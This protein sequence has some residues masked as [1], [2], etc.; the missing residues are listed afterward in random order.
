MAGRV[1][2]A[3][4]GELGDTLS[5]NPSFSLFTKRYSRYTN[6]A[7]ENYKISFP[8]GVFT[9]DFLDVPIPQK[10]GDILQEV[11]L[12]FSV[13][14]NEVDNFY[15]IDVFGISA[16]EY[17]ELYVGDEKI[18]TITAD[19][20]FIDRELNV[21]ESYRSS[22]DV[23]HGKHFQ[24][25]SEREFL[26]EFYD[27]QYNTQ[28][29][30]PFSTNEYRIQIPFYFHRRPGNG[31]PLCAIQDQELSL[32]IK[33]RPA[34]DV[35]FATQT[36]GEG[37]TLWDPAANN[38][39]TQQFELKDFKVN[40]DLVHLNT[41]E[42]CMIRSKPIDILFEQRQR[43]TFLIDPQSKSG[44]FKLDLKN[45]VKELFFI[46]KKTGQWSEEQVSLM[47]R[48]YELDNYTTAQ[49]ELL[50]ILKLIPV[51]GGVVSTTLD[52][53]THEDEQSVR[54][55]AI[56]VIRNNII[57]GDTQIGV[58]N[59][60]R[61]DENTDVSSL[62]TYITNIPGTI[63]DNQINATSNL[64]SLVGVTDGPTRADI[65]DS[66]LVS[67]ENFWGPEQI[68][69]LQALKNPLL[70]GT[71]DEEL[72][73]LGLRVY[74]T[75]VSYYLGG[76]SGLKPGTTDQL[77]TIAKLT[78]FLDSTKFTYDILKTGLKE[79]LNQIPGKTEYFRNIIVDAILI[80]GTSL[81]GADQRT[82]LES[83]RTVPVVSGDITTQ[84]QTIDELIAYLN[85]KVDIKGTTNASLEELRGETSSLAR[86]RIVNGLLAI[87]DFWGPTEEGNLR[88]LKESGLV[89]EDTLIDNLRNYV[90]A[91]TVN[92][93]A[94]LKST[95]DTIL[96]NLPYIP[97]GESRDTT[98]DGLDIADFWGTTEEG[99]LTTLK[100]TTPG[101]QEETELI[102][103]L[104]VYM[105]TK[106]VGAT[107]LTEGMVTIIQGFPSESTEERLA[108]VEVLRGVPIWGDDI[109][110]L[111]NLYDTQ[112]ETA[113]LITY[114]TRVLASIPTLKLRLDVLKAGI[115]G[116]LD[117]LPSQ[118][119]DPI[120]LGILGLHAWTQEEFGI[121]NALRT[122]SGTETLNYINALK[123]SSTAP[124]I[125][126][127]YTLF[128]QSQVIDGIISQNIWGEYYYNLND[129]RQIQPGFIGE[130][131]VVSNLTTQ[132]LD[133]ISPGST[134]GALTDGVNDTLNNLPLTLEE[135]TPIIDGI[136][137][138]PIWEGTQRVTLELLKTPSGNDSS[139][140]LQLTTHLSS[141]SSDLD[142]DYL[143]YGVNYTLTNLPTTE[144]GR[145]PIIDSMKLLPIWGEDQSTI[146]EGLKDPLVTDV[147]QLTGYINGVLT[148][149]TNALGLLDSTHTLTESDMDTLDE[150]T[151]W[152][153]EQ[154]GILQKL[155]EIVGDSSATEDYYKKL[156]ETYVK[157]LN[158]YLKTVNDGLRATITGAPTSVR[159]PVDRNILVD[160]LLRF[161]G[162]WEDDQLTLLNEFRT[163]DSVNHE[164]A[165]DAITDHLD[166]L[167]GTTI[168][169]LIGLLQT[170]GTTSADLTN[171][172][173]KI[174]A[175]GGYFYYL[176]EDLK[177]TSNPDESDIITKLVTHV[178]IT[179][180]SD[181]RNDN[182]K[183][184]LSQLTVKYPD[185]IF[186]KWIR[187]KKNVPLMY[188]KQKTTTLECDGLKILD[189]TTGSNMFLSASLPN[190]Y[191]KRS[192][193]FRNINVYSFALYPNELQPSGHLNFSTIKDAYVTMDLEYDGAHGTFDFDDN[194][195]TLFNIDPIYFPK[196]VIIIAKSYNMMI[197]R[198][199]RAQILF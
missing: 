146:L 123:S 130:S 76:L 64:I 41:V 148:V 173:D 85:L 129:L 99:Y 143:V 69:Y 3:T 4:S 138:L 120:I 77:T 112:P 59:N 25:S 109:I 93:L 111:V 168:P 116:V 125:M 86:E 71:P 60:L 57:W 84:R 197:I 132:Y 48:I 47:E 40:L 190:V 12:S 9:N 70:S 5:I 193:N 19:D 15:P 91:Q 90:D 95:I 196:Q 157:G 50:T 96:N 78:E 34:I 181:T 198:N 62:K 65:I 30:D 27:G 108:R 87:P 106:V 127:G 175:W 43:N 186:N 82:A 83:L 13:D 61:N 162:I 6:H 33:L 179:S 10:Y 169:G 67:I 23:L 156:L 22:L 163:V 159:D 107:L 45:C 115:G 142:L 155:R 165:V 152:D 118:Q 7:V 191:H 37:V 183:F 174:A 167:Y 104:R 31:F 58:L 80:Q 102:L 114:L 161:S 39:I 55:S 28:G 11:T 140:I 135:R 18:D 35:L 79:V 133:T 121:L 24:G 141:L 66:N 20:I 14:P 98:L 32:R 117:T 21:P 75:T 134:L 178:N 153:P 92:D 144:E 46:A 52:N 8:E 119:R 145:I 94:T 164:A 128:E 136:K 137:L 44:K 150:Y 158:F 97:I 17:V 36:T 139:Y 42:R 189:E 100:N 149:Y 56:D 131:N 185:T 72:L 88:T 53:L 38:R 29:I 176:L 124:A 105:N 49:N 195:I 16:I 160:V 188:S 110:K 68:G 54:E 192:P 180:L 199:G 81:W 26:Q 74:L 1:Q 101:S 177:N 166:T 172:P 103:A 113:T 151:F 184:L 73:I 170:P 126:N 89:N 182:I 63:I 147:S 2:I 171:D 187:A 194:F 154:R 51:W 122:S